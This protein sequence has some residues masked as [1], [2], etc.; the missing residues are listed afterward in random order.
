MYATP[1]P[2]L[3]PSEVGVAVGKGVCVG[4]TVAV[5]VGAKVG[6]GA[7]VAVGVGATVGAT[8]GVKVVPQLQLVLV[9]LFRIR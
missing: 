5:G 9:S 8:V 2:Q 6:V 7:T 3:D 4:A 1:V